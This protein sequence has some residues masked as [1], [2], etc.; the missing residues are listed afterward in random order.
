[1]KFSY[2]QHYIEIIYHQ[3]MFLNFLDLQIVFMFKEGKTEIE[4]FIF[5]KFQKEK[6]KNI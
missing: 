6:Q 3:N 1:M 5:I 2:V 4:K